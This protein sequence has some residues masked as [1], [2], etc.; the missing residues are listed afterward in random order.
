MRYWD[1]LQG[2]TCAPILVQISIGVRSASKAWN[3]ITWGQ[4]IPCMMGFI[5]YIYVTLTLF[6]KREG[7]PFVG[8]CSSF[9]GSVCNILCSFF[10]LVRVFLC[11]L[12]FPS[13]L[14]LLLFCL[15][16]FSLFLLGFP[17]ILLEGLLFSQGCVLICVCVCVGL[18]VSFTIACGEL[19][20]RLSGNKLPSLACNTP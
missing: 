10:P 15:D 7:F 2:A 19:C 1:D 17:C 3:V 8:Y 12:G 16:L 18:K 14:F 4:R 5:P 13:V 9:G 20:T 11:L 6:Y